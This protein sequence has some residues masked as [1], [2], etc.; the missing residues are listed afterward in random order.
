MASP[1]WALRGWGKGL[2]PVGQSSESPLALRPSGELIETH[3]HLFSADPARFPFSPLSYKPKPLPVDEYVKFAVAAKIDHAV[4]VQP[5]PYQDDHRYL[6]YSFAREPFKGFFKGTCLFDPID[7]TTPLRMRDLV[8]RNPNR[9]VALRI[10][11]IYPAET[12]PTRTGAIRDRDLKDPQMLVT[13]R[14]THELGLIMQIQSTPRFAVP[15]RELGEKVPGMPILLDHLDRPGQG[16]PEEYFQVLALAKLPQVYMKFTRTGVQSASRQPFPHLDAKPLVKRVY[17][18]FGPERILWGELGANY[19][20][21]TVEFGRCVRL[22]DT[23]FDFVPE[24]DK[25]KMRGL[26]AKRLFAFT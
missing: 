6:E 10:H 9:I 23:M 24:S 25:A 1:A 26:N 17:E 3:V 19:G 13:W 4:A 15:V 20:A 16:T 5:E 11:E 21:N 22:F 2:L 7:P 18:A 8:R 12:P 14:A